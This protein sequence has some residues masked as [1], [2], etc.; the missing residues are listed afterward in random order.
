MIKRGVL[1]SGFHNMCFSHSDEDIEYTLQVY[2]DVLYILRKAVS[3]KNVRGSLRGE[4]VQPVFR[5]TNNFHTKPR[6]S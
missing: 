1:W 4:P 2:A 5:K 3:E 6:P